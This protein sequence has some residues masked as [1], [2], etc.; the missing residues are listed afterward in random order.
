MAVMGGLELPPPR[1]DHPSMAVVPRRGWDVDVAVWR[2]WG[3]SPAVDG[4]RD[5]GMGTWGGMAAGCPHAV[6]VVWG[7]GWW[8]HLQ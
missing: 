4:D 7:E 6:L 3:L 8:P 2:H 1:R 5:T